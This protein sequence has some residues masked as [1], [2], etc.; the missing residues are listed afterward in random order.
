MHCRLRSQLNC[1]YSIAVALTIFLLADVSAA[2][3][4]MHCGQNVI[5]KGAT[6]I[7]VLKYCDE[8]DMTDLISGLEDVKT[9]VWYYD[10]APTGFLYTSQKPGMRKQAVI[11][12]IMY[13]YGSRAVSPPIQVPVTP[14][15]TSNNGKMQHV[16]ANSAPAVLPIAAGVFIFDAFTI[17]SNLSFYSD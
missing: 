2:D 11:A 9:E 17:N 6:K 3:S 15:E 7:E 4:G 10:R 14:R 13:L 8:P 16:D 5:Q 1:V 12:V